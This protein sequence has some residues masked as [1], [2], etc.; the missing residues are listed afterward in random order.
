[1]TPC[2][3]NWLLLLEF[4]KVLA[5]FAAAG[6][7][8]WLG[9]AAFR[10][11]KAIE[12]RLAWYETIHGLLGKS[13][14]AYVLAAHYLARG[15]L[16]RHKAWT[17]R[18]YEA[19]Y[20]L[21][22]QADAAW[23]YADDV[24]FDAIRTLTGHFASVDHEDLHSPLKASALAEFVTTACDDAARALSAGMRRELGLKKLRPPKD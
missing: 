1:V 24:G 9:L 13:S 23:L 2:S 6:L 18:A 14:N 22:Q 17:E 16:V 8:V 3:I 15:D 7:V 20:E 19:G 4:C 5:P 11:Q 10:R 12:R 21:Q